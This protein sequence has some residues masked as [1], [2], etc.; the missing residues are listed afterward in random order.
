[1]L[2]SAFKTYKKRVG[3]WLYLCMEKGNYILFVDYDSAGVNKKC[4]AKILVS[5]SILEKWKEIIE[6]QIG[7]I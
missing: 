3:A 2:A 7:N 4:T 5:M 6:H 1:M